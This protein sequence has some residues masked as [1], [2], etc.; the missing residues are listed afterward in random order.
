M[1]PATC[2]YP[3]IV[4]RDKEVLFSFRRHR[5]AEHSRRANFTRPSAEICGQLLRRRMTLVTTALLLC[6][7]GCSD[8]QGPPPLA[9]IRG[10]VTLDGQPLSGAGIL[11]KQ[12]GVRGS[13]SR[14]DEN[15]RYELTFH[16]DLKGAVLG[17]HRVFIGTASSEEPDKPERV[18][19][20]Y[21]RES[22]LSFTV[23]D[24]GSDAA[25]FALVLE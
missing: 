6:L 25:D 1:N 12:T 15:G 16:R 18:P 22:E 20:R 14:T 7:T 23:L 17:E 11:F 19:A 5:S 9:P 21:N 13:A 4:L 24:E 3:E 10:Q 8:V 2:F